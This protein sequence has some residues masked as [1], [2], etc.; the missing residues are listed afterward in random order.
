MTKYK[1]VLKILRCLQCRLSGSVGTDHGDSAIKTNI[2]VD[3]MQ[4]L[5]ASGIGEADFVQ[6]Q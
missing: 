6:L 3:G 4:N 2:D 5:F 1:D